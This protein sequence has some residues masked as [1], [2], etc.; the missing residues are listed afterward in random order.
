MKSVARRK[1]HDTEKGEVPGKKL[2]PANDC[3]INQ[4]ILNDNI[5][6]GF[7]RAFR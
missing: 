7:S 3:L 1:S 5:R 4:D 6:E 2:K